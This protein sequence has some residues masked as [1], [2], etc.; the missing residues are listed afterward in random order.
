[1]ITAEPIVA[2][3]GRYRVHRV[4]SGFHVCFQVE[5]QRDHKSLRR[6]RL[7]TRD[8][9]ILEFLSLPP[10]E[11]CVHLFEDEHSAAKFAVAALEAS[12]I[13]GTVGVGLA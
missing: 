6:M 11:S 4:R 3:S 5:W 8:G 2:G 9:S 13:P 10:W 1:M 7:E 12:P